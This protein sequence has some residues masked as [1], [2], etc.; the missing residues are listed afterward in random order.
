M[1]SSHGVDSDRGKAELHARAE[2]EPSTTIRTMDFQ[3]R[4]ILP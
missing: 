1:N 4:R 3:V 2:G